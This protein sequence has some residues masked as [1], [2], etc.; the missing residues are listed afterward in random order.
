M[1]LYARAVDKA[2]HI[3]FVAAGCDTFRIVHD[4]PGFRVE[5]PG[6]SNLAKTC[7]FG[8]ACFNGRSG[9]QGSGK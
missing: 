1:L 5:R 7:F 2:S 6:G 4:V 8:R 3:T 9:L